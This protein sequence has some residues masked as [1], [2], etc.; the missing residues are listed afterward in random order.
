MP[1]K[2]VAD[3]S[4]ICGEEFQGKKGVGGE[5]HSRHDTMMSEPECTYGTDN[6]TAVGV[7]AAVLEPKPESFGVLHGGH[8]GSLQH[9]VLAEKLVR[10]ADLVVFVLGF[11]EFLGSG[12]SD[13]GNL[14]NVVGGGVVLPLLHLVVRHLGAVG[15]IS[16][17]LWTEK[18]NKK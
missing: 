9:Q 17:G 1:W 6:G 5:N 14:G 2:K 16:F 8:V 15:V 18:T 3:F 10:G 4:A 12:G 11:G 7:D 13:T